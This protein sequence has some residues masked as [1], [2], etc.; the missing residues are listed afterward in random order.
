MVRRLAFALA[1]AA[2]GS[3]GGGVGDDAPAKASD[4]P[5]LVDAPPLTGPCG[6]RSGMRGKTART[7]TAAGLDR[8]YTV[9]LPPSVDPAT[10]IPFV[11]VFHGYTMS[12]SEMFDI[13]QYSELADSEHIAVVFPDGQGGPDSLGAPW[14]V[15]ANVCPDSLGAPP[16]ATGDD[17]AFLDAMKADVW[18]DQCLDTDHEFVTGFSMGGYFSHHTGCMR[19]DIRSVAPHS[20]GTHDLSACPT[21]HKPIIIFHGTADPV[22]P[23]GCDDPAG[24]TPAGYTASATMWA[25]KNGCGTT[26]TTMPVA[27]GSCAYYDGCPADGQVALCTLTGMGHCWAGGPAS[28]GIYAC[29]GYAS[30]TQLEWTFWKTYAW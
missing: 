19:D 10:P 18:Q 22:V 27:M 23:E 3:H 5:P 8:T 4:A 9:Y 21:G 28:A 2:C 25:Q 6:T 26:T 20:G 16:D 29:P 15:G 14:N 24:N 12:G 17:F 30:A 7:V 13:T 1:L 11:A